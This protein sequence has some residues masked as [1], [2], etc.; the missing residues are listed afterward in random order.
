MI[1]AEVITHE[2]TPIPNWVDRCRM[3]LE[4]TKSAPLLLLLLVAA[5]C[6]IIFYRHQQVVYHEP[7]G[8]L[9]AINTPP[10]MVDTPSLADQVNSLT[11]TSTTEDPSPVTTNVDA[12]AQLSAPRTKY[13]KSS[14]NQTV[15][16]LQDTASQANRHINN[17]NKQ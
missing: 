10:L 11:D 3:L 5:L 16:N 12:N 7:V 15:G 14:L 6:A 2:G 9:P 17:S 4:P 13:G 1:K 8:T